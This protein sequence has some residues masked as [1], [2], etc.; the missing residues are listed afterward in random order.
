MVSGAARG[1]WQ[2]SLSLTYLTPDIVGA[3]YLDWK[4]TTARTPISERR[5]AASVGVIITALEEVL[6]TGWTRHE[7]TRALEESS[8]DVEIVRHGK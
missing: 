6:P 7:M 3:C 4:N 5:L 2:F 8:D 1:Y